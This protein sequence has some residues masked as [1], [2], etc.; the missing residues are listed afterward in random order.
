MPRIGRTLCLVLT[1]GLLVAGLAVLTRLPFGPDE[2]TAQSAPRPG[3][4]SAEEQS[5]LVPG[6]KLSFFK[7]IAPAAQPKTPSEE[8]PPPPVQPAAWETAPTDI[9]L[10][11][12]V[13]LHVPSG[14]A[15]SPFVR[16]GPFRAEFSGYLKTANKGEYGFQPEGQGAFELIVNG[17]SIVQIPNSDFRGVTPVRVP[18]YKG[19][20]AVRIVYHSPLQGDATLRLFW[21]GD[22]FSPEP[23][24]PESLFV[25]GNEAALQKQ[26]V[27]RS[28]RDLFASR[29]CL[30]C[31]ALPPT[32]MPR[33]LRMPELNQEPPQLANLAERLR[34]EWIVEWLLDP[35]TLRPQATMPQLL[36]SLPADQSLQQAADLVSYLFDATQ[37]EAA[38]GTEATTK[39]TPSKKSAAT[40]SPPVPPAGASESK[41]D[42]TAENDPVAAGSKLFERLGCIGCHRFTPPAEADPEQ[43]LSLA[44]IPS[45]FQPGQLRAFMAAPGKHYAWSR[46]PDF[47]LQEQELDSLLAY[48]QSAA[49]GQLPDRKVPA[50]DRVR[51]QKL[52]LEYGCLHCHSVRAAPRPATAPDFLI[53][54]AA[55]FDPEKSQHGCLAEAAE[56]AT[57]P[58]RSAAAERKAGRPVGVP[59]WNFTAQELSSV[60]QFLAV[61]LASLELDHPTEFAERQ[62]TQLRCQVCHRRDGQQ[63]RLPIILEEESQLG[64]MPEWLPL[65]TWTGEKL[66]PQWTQKLLAGEL[67]QRARHWL[68]AR[69]PAFPERADL[70]AAGLSFEHGFALQEDPRPPADPSQV[71]TGRKL[72]GE[73]GGLACVK[74]HAVGKTPA[75]QPFEAPG[76][77]LQDAALRLRY[78]YYPR[79]MMDPPRVDLAVRMPKFAQ[80][81]KTTGITEIYDG[82][83]RQQYEALWQYIQSL[84]TADD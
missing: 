4:L 33:T 40:N 67:D 15:P 36:H 79:W 35:R 6:L 13:A 80:D 18:L 74:C 50:G 9:R 31:H 19:F 65:L 71:E 28:G 1:S 48:L 69:M 66:Q 16:P 82:N 58:T 24:P 5:A 76:I 64:L 20:N 8:Q 61:G 54:F 14:M 47:H 25:P 77:N 23:L 49:K 10:T 46:M 22:D 2:V 63:S 59:R 38:S 53:P 27:L 84:K 21:K 62:I 56:S 3:R 73:V 44:L 12:L 52:A 81:N 17:Q 42:A 41:T 55:T 70:I 34:P 39:P 60:R 26:T 45:K 7:P 83:A 43:R 29:H 72:A 68:V 37:A 78:S 75:K 32:A 30:A 51:G 57:P 11:R